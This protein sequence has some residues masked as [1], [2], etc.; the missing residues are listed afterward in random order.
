MPVNRLLTDEDRENYKP[1]ID[2]MKQLC[3][4]M[5]SRKIDRA[6]VQ[7]AFVLETVLGELKDSDWKEKDILCV[8]SFEDTACESLKNMGVAVV[9]IDPDINEDLHTFV[10]STDKTFDIVFSTSVIEHVEDDSQFVKDICFLLKPNGLSI[11][12]CDFNNNYEVGDKLPY[13]DKRF[14]TKNSLSK[15]ITTIGKL[16]CSLV[17]SPNW[18]GEPDFEHDGCKYS[19]STFV[20]RR[21]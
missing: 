9:E 13:S 4:E 2:K 14:Y 11:I 7:Q 17:D 1:L 3:P 19:F 5:M 21:K 10:S 6:N 12:T 16:F 8:G 15:F 20:F 18:E